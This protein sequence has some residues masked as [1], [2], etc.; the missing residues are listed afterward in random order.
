MGGSLT[1]PASGTYIQV[2]GMNKTKTDFVTPTMPG[3]LAYTDGGS[4]A[5]TVK[6]GKTVMPVIKHFDTFTGSNTIGADCVIVGTMV[7]G[8]WCWRRYLHITKRSP[9][10]S[11]SRSLYLSG[12][13]LR[14]SIFDTRKA[15]TGVIKI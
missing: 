14:K 9:I 8:C 10:F 12:E 1:V 15:T 4:P 5:N 2:G 13:P 3:S 11:W 6:V 7:S